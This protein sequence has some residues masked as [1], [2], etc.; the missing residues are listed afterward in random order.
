MD[1]FCNL[2]YKLIDS[3]KNPSTLKQMTYF[4]FDNNP[5]LSIKYHINPKNPENVCV[6][7]KFKKYKKNEVIYIFDSS[8]L[9]KNPS[10][11][12]IEKWKYSLFKYHIEMKKRHERDIILNH[13][14]F[15]NSIYKTY[16]DGNRINYKVSNFKT[17]EEVKSIIIEKKPLIEMFDTLKTWLSI[18]FIRLQLDDKIFIKEN[19]YFEQYLS[20]YEEYQYEDVT[21]KMQKMKEKD[22]K[23]YF[24]IEVFQLDVEKE[25]AIKKSNKNPEKLS[26]KRVIS[27]KD[28]Y[29]EDNNK[30]H[31]QVCLNTKYALLNRLEQ[32]I[33]F[34]N[35]EKENIIETRDFSF[36]GELFVPVES[37][38]FEKYIPFEEDGADIMEQK[39]EKCFKSVITKKTW[40]MLEKKIV[41]NFCQKCFQMYHV[42]YNLRRI[43]NM[44]HF[45]SIVQFFFQY[46]N[47]SQIENEHMF[48]LNFKNSHYENNLSVRVS[49][50]KNNEFHFYIKK[51][52]GKDQIETF[53]HCFFEL[54]LTIQKRKKYYFLNYHSYNSNLKNYIRMNEISDIFVISVKEFDKQLFDENNMNHE[55][56]LMRAICPQDEMKKEDR[57]SCKEVLKHFLY[58]RYCDKKRM[59]YI[60][61]EKPNEEDYNI[62]TWPNTEK[63]SKENNFTIFLKSPKYKH[64]IQIL[65][66]YSNNFTMLIKQ[67]T[68]KK[69]TEEKVVEFSLIYFYIEKNSKKYLSVTNLSPGFLP[70]ITM[71]QKTNEDCS[72]YMTKKRKLEKKLDDFFVSFCNDPD[73]KFY[74]EK[75]YS[76]ENLLRAFQTEHV[77]SSDRVSTREKIYFKVSEEKKF[78]DIK[79]IY[80][81]CCHLVQANIIV[82][83]TKHKNTVYDFKSICDSEKW[84]FTFF[85]RFFFL[86]ECVDDKN[87]EGIISHYYQPVC[88][89]K[90]NQVFYFFDQKNNKNFFLDLI[91]IYQHVILNSNKI[92]QWEK[93]KQFEETVSCQTLDCYGN[94]K[95]LHFVNGMIVFLSSNIPFLD[96]NYQF[97][98]KK[99]SILSMKNN[100]ELQSKIDECIPFPWD[101]D[102]NYALDDNLYVYTIT[103]SLE[104]NLNIKAG[105][106]YFCQ[107]VQSNM[108]QQ[109]IPELYKKEISYY[110]E[111][112]IIHDLTIYKDSFIHNNICKQE[113]LK[114]Y[115]RFVDKK[116]KHNLSNKKLVKDFIT[117]HILFTKGLKDYIHTKRQRKMKVP[118]CYEYN[119]TYYLQWFSNLTNKKQFIQNLEKKFLYTFQFTKKKN[120]IINV[121][122]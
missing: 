27:I 31:L 32:V 17:R 44:T 55:S 72:N 47:F 70:S 83:H 2:H 68:N 48:M 60:S 64:P 11:K 14:M 76:L 52:C 41:G 38:P 9:M 28:F 15:L 37:L 58:T 50:N 5:I 98:L 81:Y 109:I 84:N 88:Y 67:D 57:F 94:T 107:D 87:N 96:K 80:H 79:F 3:K 105:F 77:V 113:I 82:L 45:D 108:T 24:E 118:E 121:Y 99:E 56:S 43:L 91:D 54:L 86:I 20:D 122:E 29:Q 89:E 7:S 97:K 101:L 8:C 53:L 26:L 1:L 120:T 13:I 114:K 106:L 74:M 61:F 104:N 103:I 33:C 100:K 63:F 25:I 30:L 92:F 115:L 119:L 73:V 21:I 59:P 110:F 19:E 116:K 102:E 39:C 22:Y 34:L 65:Q 66:N 23:N 95:F 18:P 93:M 4:S 90:N 42:E 75:K 16:F 35:L 112:K 12:E 111:E 71:K 10:E 69:L 85:N 51:S 117:K 49:I 36:T 6:S 78:T 40:N 62:I 46:A